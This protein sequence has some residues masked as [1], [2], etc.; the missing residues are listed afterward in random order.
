MEVTGFLNDKVYDSI[1]KRLLS[2]WCGLS[3]FVYPANIYLQSTKTPLCS[4]RCI[5]ITL[6]LLLYLKISEIECHTAHKALHGRAASHG[7]QDLFECAKQLFA[8]PLHIANGFKIPHKTQMFTGW[9]RGDLCVIL[10][11]VHVSKKHSAYRNKICNMS[12]TK[13]YILL[14]VN[15]ICIFYTAPVLRIGAYIYTN[16]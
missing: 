1:N 9:Q 16:C 3:V 14:Y 11:A 13:A 12:C 15:Q 8:K 7:P 2:A 10:S 4:I 6:L 5:F